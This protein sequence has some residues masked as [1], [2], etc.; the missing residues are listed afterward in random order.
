MLVGGEG[1][2]IQHKSLN[3]ARSFCSLQTVQVY[4]QWLNASDPVPNIQ[5]AAFNRFKTTPQNKVTDY[6]TVPARVRAVFITE[7]V[8][9]PG[10]FTLFA[11]GQQP[12]QKR[13][14]GSNVLNT[15]FTVEGPVTP[16]AK[17][18]L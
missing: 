17:C 15:T 3:P 14:V 18:P 5:L 7:L 12:G 13:Q 1:Q 9:E 10:V 2:A 4:I 6:L 11:G 16:L 8:L